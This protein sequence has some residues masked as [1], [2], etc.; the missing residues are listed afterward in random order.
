VLDQ[1][2]SEKRSDRHDAYEE[3]RVEADET[4]HLSGGMPVV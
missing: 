1:G 4:R 3:E 2:R